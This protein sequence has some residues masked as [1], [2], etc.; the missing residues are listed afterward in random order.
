MLQAHMTPNETLHASE[1]AVQPADLRLAPPQM[2][3]RYSC[4]KSHELLLKPTQRAELSWVFIMSTT[5]NP[6]ANPSNNATA[7][8]HVTCKALPAE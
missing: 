7:M 5:S 8:V 1:A 3:I 6:S 4:L 2:Y